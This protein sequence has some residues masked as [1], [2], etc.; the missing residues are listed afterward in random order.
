MIEDA[1]WE[2]IDDT[3]TPRRC[4]WEETETPIPI[5]IPRKE[6]TFQIIVRNRKIKQLVLSEQL[7]REFVN[8]ILQRALPDGNKQ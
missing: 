7:A 5:L 6:G 8:M 1:Q 4:M 3:D 2:Q